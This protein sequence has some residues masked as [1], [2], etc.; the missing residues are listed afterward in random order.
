MRTLIV[1]AFL[2]FLAPQLTTAEVRITVKQRTATTVYLAGGSADGLIVGDRL[3]IAA[4]GQ[5]VAEIEVVFLAEHSASC[6]VVRETKPVKAGDIALLPQTRAPA[7][8]AEGVTETTAPSAA[9]AAPAGAGWTKPEPARPWARVRGGV[10][11]RW[12]KLKDDTERAADFEQRSGRF[13]LSVWD[14]R[15]APLELNLRARSRQDIRSFPTG[16]E[17][18]P[19]DERRDRLY[20]AALRYR[21]RGER[22]VLEAGRIGISTLG[23]GY[24]DGVAADVRVVRSFRA[25]GFFGSRAD[26]DNTTDFAHGSKYGGFLRMA[27][28]RAF[29]TG[30]YD[31]LLYGVREMA[32]A[33]VSR[34]YVGFQGRYGGRRFST[35]QWAEVDI[36]RGWRQDAAGGKTHDLSNLSVSASY[37]AQAMTY[38]RVSYDIRRNYRSAETRSI[39]DVLFDTFARQGLRGG[40]D[41]VRANG[42]AA[43]GFVGVR[44]RDP[45]SDTA[46]SYGG[47][48]RYASPQRTRLTGGIDVSGF[49]NGTTKGYQIGV[50]VGRTLKSV[51]L[52]GAWGRSAYTF[53]AAT[54]PQRTNQWFR[55]SALTVL[56]RG[57]WLNGDLQ[58]DHGDDSRGPRGGFEVGYRF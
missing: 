4:G 17:S 6:K 3:T 37:R 25:G 54:Q 24:L 2:A 43:S 19:A 12:N 35:V 21:P 52:D 39:P 26:V 27:P 45:S 5:T 55:L 22:V 34:E 40:I 16:F 33:D 58:Y 18:L 51:T 13:D 10:S 14:V 50:R 47:N 31:A 23:V 49:S 57:L 32:S 41:V 38:L 20:E 28:S 29:G 7:T 56:P 30:S 36:L 44:L 9:Q 15:D 53:A 11:L 8:P 1:G 46:Y 42:V 48:F